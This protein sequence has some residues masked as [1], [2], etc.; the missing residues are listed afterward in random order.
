MV[1][2][3]FRAP[4]EPRKRLLRGMELVNNPPLLPQRP[5]SLQHLRASDNLFFT[6]RRR[7]SSA[8]CQRFKLPQ[9]DIFTTPLAFLTSMSGLFLFMPEV[10]TS[11][12]VSREGI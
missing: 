6:I 2:V 8:W 1:A 11:I 9:G 4:E 12:E 10:V 5:E 7:K 3:S